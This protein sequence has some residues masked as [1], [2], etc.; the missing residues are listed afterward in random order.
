MFV[1]VEPRRGDVDEGG[2]IEF[3]SVIINSLPTFW[4]LL[5]DIFCFFFIGPVVELAVDEEDAV[6]WND[7]DDGREWWI[8]FA[9]SSVLSRSPGG[10]LQLYVSN[11]LSFSTESKPYV[12]QSFLFPK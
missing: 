11:W 1:S 7:D 8:N 2:G 10:P 6:R 12:K 4:F 5:L 3:S 9:S